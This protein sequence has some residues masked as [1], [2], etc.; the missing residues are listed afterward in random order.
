[1]KVGSRLDVVRGETENKCKAVLERLRQ[2]LN[3]THVALGFSSDDRFLFRS[4]LMTDQDHVVAALRTDEGLMGYCLKTGKTWCYPDDPITKNIIRT[5]AR[6]PVTEIVSPVFYNG[7]PT[8]VLLVDFFA[9]DKLVKITNQF[10]TKVEQAAAEISAILE[11]QSKT[12]QGLQNS[13]LKIV[14]DCKIRT[15]SVR[16]YLAI[17][18]WDGKLQ[19]IT[20]ESDDSIFLALNQTEGLCGRVFQ[21]GEPLNFGNVWDAEGY[22]ASDTSVQSE[23][24]YPIRVDGVVVAVL[25]M[26]SDRSD[27]YDDIKEEA[28]K[29]SAALLTDLVAQYRMLDLEHVNSIDAQHAYVSDFIEQASTHFRLMKKISATSVHIE[30]TR[31]IEERLR[32][33]FKAEKPVIWDTPAAPPVE[34]KGLSWEQRIE[35]GCRLING[36]ESAKKYLVYSPL[37]IDGQ[38]KAVIG[39][40]TND[41]PPEIAQHVAE[42]FCRIGSSIAELTIE[43]YR[44]ALFERLVRNLLARRDRE[45]LSDVVRD[46]PSIIDCD[47]CTVLGTKQVDGCDVLIP[48]ASSSENVFK[49]YDS[50]LFYRMGPDVYDGFT[51]FVG[52]T[53]NP[54][55]RYPPQDSERLTP[56]SEGQPPWARKTSEVREDLAALLVLPIIDPETGRVTGALRVVRTKRH[57]KA[58]TPL[59]ARFVER[60]ETICSML[61]EMFGSSGLVSAARRRERRDI[62]QSKQKRTAAR[63]LAK[64]HRKRSDKLPDLDSKSDI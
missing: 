41:P 28:I 47:H 1:M 30:I 53:G 43:N 21:K 31:F 58:R 26:E 56:V 40:V 38:L 46:V 60:L 9:G 15:G 3:L 45:G 61:G 23:C 19:Y 7:E 11:D 13:I 64:S 62:S 54:L 51:G 36:G 8:A 37:R 34:M 20:T 4:A 22:V 6:R 48:L 32:R 63:K 12:R 59:E 33:L 52:M 17:K 27:Y 49:D 5:I 35:E 55:T 39:F 57:R 44:S 42:Q 29:K 50:Q 25:N 18:G 10:R 16:G 24:I 14:S 2:D